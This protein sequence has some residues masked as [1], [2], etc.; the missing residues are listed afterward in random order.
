M[1]HLWALP[2]SFKNVLFDCIVSLVQLG[3]GF[4]ILF[5]DSPS[6]LLPSPMGLIAGAGIG[7]VCLVFQIFYN[8]GV[9]LRRSD[10]TGTFVASQLLML[11]FFV[12]AAELFYR[13]VFFNRLA[14]IW[15][16]GTALLLSTSLSTMITVVSTRKPL[17]WLGAAVVGALSCLGF[18]YSGSMWAPVLIRIGND[19]GSR[20]LNDPRDFFNSPAAP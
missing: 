14:H 4:A 3:F 7:S 12:P 1:I 2:Y 19:I 13:G 6:S 16:V 18:Y 15:G 8:R 20:T 10:L 17:D 9:K 5:F 11:V